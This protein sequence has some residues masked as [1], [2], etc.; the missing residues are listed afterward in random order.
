M[1]KRPSPIGKVAKP[2]EETFLSLISQEEKWMKEQSSTSIQVSK[3]KKI[4][5]SYKPKYRIKEYM[6]VL[7]TGSFHQIYL[8]T[9]FC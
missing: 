1:K 3:K 7:P 5:E 2:S 4:D 8:Q 9:Q 6:H